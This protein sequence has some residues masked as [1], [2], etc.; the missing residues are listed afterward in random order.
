MC[1]GI[2]VNKEKTG[3]LLRLM[4][5]KIKPLYHTKLLKLVYLI[6]ETAVLECGSPVTWLNYKAWQFGPVAEPVYYAKFNIQGPLSEYVE[7]QQD[8]NGFKVMAK[9]EFSDDEFSDYEIELI[10]KVIDKYANSSCNELIRLTHRIDGLWQTTV[11]NY[12]IKFN[13]DTPISPYI[14]NFR[15]LIAGTEKEYIYNEIES[16]MNFEASLKN[17]GC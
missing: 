16:A 9:G 10:Q 14:L 11:K 3:N 12:D 6:D 4:A 5:E 15:E 8:D 1:L 13:N 17:S 2:S 7:F